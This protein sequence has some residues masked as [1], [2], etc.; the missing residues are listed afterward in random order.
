MVETA[1]AKQS[2]ADIEARHGDIIKLEKSIKELH[3]MFIDM[4]AL[5][6]TQV[7]SSSSSVNEADERE[8]SI[9]R[10]KWSIESNTTLFNQRIS[11]KQRVQIRKKLWNSKVPLDG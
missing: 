11:S 6:Q 2:L 4:A 5:V 9:C 7:N 1:Q 10:E 3:D 8:R